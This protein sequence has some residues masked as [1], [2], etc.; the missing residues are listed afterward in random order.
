MKFFHGALFL[1]K[2][3]LYIC[4]GLVYVLDCIQTRR[5]SQLDFYLRRH[6]KSIVYS[7]DIANVQQLRQIINVAFETLKTQ[8]VTLENVRRA[9]QRCVQ[10]NGQYFQQLSS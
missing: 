9:T 1:R 6:V 10:Q 4:R 2:I 7:N 3:T 5:M 8:N